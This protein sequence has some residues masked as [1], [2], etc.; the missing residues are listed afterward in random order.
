MK[1]NAPSR[2][3]RRTD[4]NI[5]ITADSLKNR[6]TSSGSPSKPVVTVD[7]FELSDGDVGEGHTSTEF[8]TH[9]TLSGKEII[10]KN[11]LV[12]GKSDHQASIVLFQSWLRLPQL[13]YFPHD[14]IVQR[15]EAKMTARK[16]G[17][18]DDLAESKFD[19][20]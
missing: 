16:R 20:N 9:H 11:N 8:I 5:T 15:R 17:R 10:L 14:H 6:A 2:H 4:Q 13:C 12:G 19:R 1:S 7:M 3:T 18:S